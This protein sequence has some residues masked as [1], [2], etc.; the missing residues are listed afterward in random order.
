MDMSRYM[1]LFVEESREHLTAL[2]SRIAALTGNPK[3]VCV[4]Q[5]KAN[6]VAAKADAKT[7]K[8]V[9]TTR[10]DAADEK[11]DAQYKVAAEKCDALSGDAKSSCIKSAKARYG[12][13]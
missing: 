11:R 13:T 8:T 4:K 6:H 9:A 7:V 1:K 10:I 12:K 3:D 2:S 5:A